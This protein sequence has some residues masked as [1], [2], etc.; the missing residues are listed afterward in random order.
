M[1]NKN[2]RE[3]EKHW[4][5]QQKK[6]EKPNAAPKRKSREDMNQVGEQIVREAIKD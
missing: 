1:K 6:S 3:L 2:Q 5:K 4:T